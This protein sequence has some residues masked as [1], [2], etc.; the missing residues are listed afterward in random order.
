MS[1][2]LDESPCP[3]CGQPVS[4][5]ATTSQAGDQLALARTQCPACGAPLARAIE[6]HAD[7]GWRLA[8]ESANDG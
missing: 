4:A 5:T 3:R 7:R 1:S 8:E 6:G 2:P